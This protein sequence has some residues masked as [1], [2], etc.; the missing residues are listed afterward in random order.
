MGNTHGK[1]AVFKLDDVSDLLTDISAF[2]DQSDF[3]RVVELADTTN[4]GDEDRTFIPGLG[5]A[6]I[7]IGGPFEDTLDA[8]IGT[9]V[10][11]KVS[12]GF[13]FD[14]IGAGTAGRITGECFIT[15]YTTGIPVGDNV[16]WTATL[17]TTGALTRESS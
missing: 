3:A 10:Q 2:V 17:T 16:V 7:S 8:I 9:P 14:P 5:T 1:D 12:R 13:D 15:N 6:S 11:Q 4:Y